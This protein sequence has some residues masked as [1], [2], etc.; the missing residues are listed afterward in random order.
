MHARRLAPG[1][2]QQPFLRTPHDRIP[3]GR[4]IGIDVP[5]RARA[6]GANDDPAVV[7]PRRAKHAEEVLGEILGD[8]V[9]GTN[10]GALLREARVE[11]VERKIVVRVCGVADVR[12]QGDRDWPGLQVGRPELLNQVL[13]SVL[14]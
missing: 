3:R 4:G 14:V 12:A 7:G 1:R 6:L 9:I 10:G 8:G 13:L 11:D 2:Q 5:H